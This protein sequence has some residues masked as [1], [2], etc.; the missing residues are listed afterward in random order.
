[1]INKEALVAC[2]ANLDKLATHLEGKGMIKEAANL[3]VIANTVEANVPDTEPGNP[4]DE[5]ARLD[6]YVGVGD[7]KIHDFPVGNNNMDKVVFGIDNAKGYNPSFSSE[8]PVNIQSSRN[9]V[10]ENVSLQDLTDKNLS[11]QLYDLGDE[12][13]DLTTGGLPAEGGDPA[14][15]GDQVGG[16][17][18]N[19]GTKPEGSI[20]AS[21]NNKKQALV[22][23][24]TAGVLSKKEAND[25]WGYIVK[26]C[27]GAGC[28]E[29]NKA[30]TKEISPNE[31]EN[32][33]VASM[34]A[35]LFPVPHKANHEK[36]VKAAQRVVKAGRHLTDDR[37]PNFKLVA[38]VYN[39]MI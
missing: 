16:T 8:G 28:N 20:H 1:M 11:K 18:P 30:D 23:A 25:R 5:A 35:R 3:D 10:A 21:L 24:V 14:L 4:A 6:G 39:E 26:S 2:V 37:Q 13:D 22:N 27:E 9:R 33:T 19:T 34:A 17:I 15:D 31:K 29:Q 38:D 32:Y 36:Y 7:G 12:E